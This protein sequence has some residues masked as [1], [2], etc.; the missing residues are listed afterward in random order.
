MKKIGLALGGGGAKGFAHLPILEVFDELGIKPD[1]ITGT[2]IGGILGA[3]YASGQSA[4]DIVEMFQKLITPPDARFRDMIRS[5]DMLQIVKLIDPHISL[6]PNGLLKGEK[7]LY[8]LYDQMQVSTF[9]E[10]SI[11][12]KVV[13]T[14]FW[15]KEQVVFD[16]GALLRAVRAS[17][18][19]PYIFAPV[20][21]EDRVLVDGGL[22]NNVPHDLL[23][24]DCDLRIAVD[25]SGQ[26]SKPVT[27]IPSPR[28]A[29]MHTYQVMMDTIAAERLKNHPVDIYICPPL[30]DVEILDFHKPWEIYQQ[31][32]PAKDPF[33]RQLEQAFTEGPKRRK[34][35]W[36]RK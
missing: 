13:A 25:L 4:R 36:K 32:L 11:P 30:L 16:S 34:W 10:L 17:M 31:A 18:A 33:K 20:V 27:K 24:P 1:C 21:D 35:T 22:V 15:R 7:L 28:D 8:Y 29:I 2:S 3:L 12:L 26:K 23:D 9:E 6:K 5:K 14:D 19:L